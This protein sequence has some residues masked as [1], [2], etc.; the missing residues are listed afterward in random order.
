MRR[1]W[2]EIMP[3]PVARTLRTSLPP[4]GGSGLKWSHCR[5]CLQLSRSPSMR[6]EWI[7]MA[8]KT[9]DLHRSV[10]SP[11]MRREWIEIRETLF[12]EKLLA[13]SLH[14]EGVDWNINY[15]YIICKHNC[16]PP[17]GGS[18][19]KFKYAWNTCFNVWSPSMRREWIEI[20]SLKDELHGAESPSMRREWIEITWQQRTFS[21]PSR[22]PPCGGSGLKWKEAG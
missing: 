7:E 3:S 12:F 20:Q 13:V 14:A 11:S 4:C 17:C 16:L 9:Y 15:W 18:G 10:R 6:R 22:L 8:C 5:I 21:M 2:I 19:L 1:E